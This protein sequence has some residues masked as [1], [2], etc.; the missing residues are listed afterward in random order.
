MII[1]SDFLRDNYGQVIRIYPSAS[2]ELLISTPT[3]LD[4]SWSEPSYTIPTEG[5]EYRTLADSAG[6]T[7]YAYVVRIE[8]EEEI[9]HEIRISDVAPTAQ[10]KG[11]WREPK[12]G[13]SLVETAADTGNE[14][15][16][17]FEDLSGTDWY[18]YPT[19]DGELRITTSQPS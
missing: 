12:Y 17:A 9:Q 3:Q 15:Y 5:Y 14:I 6:N 13:I 7:W 10:S 16:L 2:G 19:V 8:T 1:L 18:V 4:D 11:V